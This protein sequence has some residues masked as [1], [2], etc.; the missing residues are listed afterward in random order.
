MALKNETIF[1]KVSTNVNN[2]KIQLYNFETTLYESIVD[3]DIA[4]CEGSVEIDNTDGK[5]TNTNLISRY[6][7]VFSY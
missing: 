4:T 3:C 7:L 1:Y 5:Y 2:F 6:L